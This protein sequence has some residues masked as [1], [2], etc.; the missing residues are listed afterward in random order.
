MIKDL[1]TRRRLPRAGVIRLGIKVKNSSGK[2]YP[3]ET[4]YF[5]CPEIVKDF[6][7]PEPKELLVMFPVE[8]E[9]V[10]F[11]QF[12]KKYGNGVLLCRGDGEV[13]TYYDFDS[14]GFTDKK[15]PCESIEKKE[16]KQ[17][18][19]LQFLLPEIKEAIGVFQIST[20]STNSIVDVNSG[21]DLVRSIAGRVRMIPLILKREETNTQKIDDG[22]VIKGKHYTMKLSF[23]MSLME[24][25]KLGQ[26]D[27][28]MVLLPRP[29]ETV[30]AVDD[31]FPENGFE[32]TKE[33]EEPTSTM[34]EIKDESDLLKLKKELSGLL[35]ET[36]EAGHSLTEEE[37]LKLDAIQTIGE[38]KGAIRYWKKELKELQSEDIPVD[39]P[40][41]DLPF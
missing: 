7:G 2:E 37:A 23:G 13:A 18:A 4:D 28:T 31:L 30:E 5:V 15:C 40:S 10:F 25:Q 32:P 41:E 36:K 19:I 21:I 33:L 3:K 6:Y 38:Y 16:C 11:Q 12:Y 22:K 34:E 20:S 14:K 39:S 26:V 35:E 1:S 27:P 17:V 29:D 8:S 24:I 9:Q